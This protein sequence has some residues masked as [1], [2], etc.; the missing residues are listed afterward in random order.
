MCEGMIWCVCFGNNPGVGVIQGYVEERVIQGCV[1]RGVID[2]GIGGEGH[3]GVWKEGI[4]QLCV[5]EEVM[6]VCGGWKGDLEV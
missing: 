2:P 6:H 1:W 4:I 3:R 5:K